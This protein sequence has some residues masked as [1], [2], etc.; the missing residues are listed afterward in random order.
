MIEILPAIDIRDG[1]CVRLRQGDYERETVFD[2]DPAAAARRWID[3]GASRLHVV[4]LDGAREGRAVNVD[5][6][7][8]IINLG[9]P[10]QIGGGVR[11]ANTV[12]RYRELGAARIILGTAAISDPAFLRETLNG[13][14]DGIIVS[15]DAR[16]GEV[17]VAGWTES[18]G[19]SAVELA[20]DLEHAGVRR[21]IYT[22]IASDGMLSGHDQAALS[23]IVAAVAIPLIAAG[24][25]ASREQIAS[26]RSAGAAGVVLGRSLYDG[27]LSLADALR[28]ATEPPQC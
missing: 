8:R 6:V 4:D 5:A 20:R 10:V 3:Q 1:R 28:A 2:E 23:R 14:A 24:G 19:R 22:D 12:A 17:A 25:I 7:A 21:L 26:L 16:G 27:R 9:L 18:S 13:G 15:V 11:D